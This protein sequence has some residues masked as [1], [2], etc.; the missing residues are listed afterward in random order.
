MSKIKTTSAIES[1]ISLRKKVLF[2]L[3][4]TMLFFGGLEIVLTVAGVRPLLYDEDPHVGFVS[5]IPLFVEGKNGEMMTAPN[6]LRWFNEQRFERNK[7]EGVIRVF[8]VG[9]STT[10]GR[11]YADSTSFCGWLREY[12]PVADPTKTWE[13][14]NA[15]G[16]SYASYRVAKL[17]EELAS[18][19]PDVF[20]IYSGHNEFLEE[21]TY[22]GIIETPEAVL[23]MQ[24]ALGHT[25]TYSFMAGLLH[26][27]RTSKN[28]SATPV[29]S[30]E[31]DTI[32]DHS[33]G[34]ERYTRDE[35][36]EAD[37]MAHYRYNLARMVDIAQ[38]ANAR[39]IFISPASNLGNASP[40][41]SEHDGGMTELLVRDW[42]ALLLSAQRDLAA[43]HYE[44]ALSAINRALAMDPLHA[45]TL[46][47]RGQ[48]LEALER[49]EDAK[50]SYIAALENDVCPLRILPKMRAIL[51]ETAASRGVD[52]FDYD[53]FLVER[54]AHG[55][56]G[57]EWFLDHVHPTVEGHRL[58][59]L[60]VIKVMETDG[61]LHEGSAL[62]DDSIQKIKARVLAGI[63]DEAQGIALRNLGNVLNWAGKKE[64]AYAAA[65]KALKLA[66]G[67]AYTHYLLGD[68]AGSL[69]E[70]T[71][72][73]EHFR[74]LIRFDLNT[75]DAPYFPDAHYQLAQIV[76]AR[77]NTG[78]S[79]KL[80]QKTLELQPDHKGA[81][82]ALPIVLEA[83]GKKLLQR[84]RTAE[85]VAIFRKLVSLVP[86]IGMAANFLGA[87][88]I[89]D[90]KIPEAIE[91]LETAVANDPQNPGIHN[92][93][94]SAFAQSG[95]G[96][97]AAH[98]FETAIQ[99]N[100]DHADAH[101]NYA[102]LLESTGKLDLAAD[103]Y[104]MVLKLQPSSAEAA[105]AL[106]RILQQVK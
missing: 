76:G 33:A 95:N 24:A 37:I 91:V 87:A 8:C 102:R 45:H 67:D 89:Q 5:S 6:K 68:L 83:H 28:T 100:P 74:E 17:M 70:T 27:S 32:L 15:G 36:L 64:E 54:S 97:E 23:G 94:G 50:A 47:L 81:E 55:I 22:S 48:V 99:L 66:P 21:R 49:Y 2:S 30:E 40:F 34:L 25:R 59:A 53:R 11:P 82:A 84:G 26:R 56:P 106:K 51:A 29:L 60:E 38:S 101:L 86:K 44:E 93:L 31:V 80:I 13:V 75:R 79:L 77:G 78:E 69:G 90:K 20:V 105:E 92:N 35:K 57:D 98:H 12:L 58:L 7:P 39:V 85:A 52:I 4:T 104:R 96:E 62:S 10:Y 16:I 72:A 1:R 65:T 19:E 9:G 103:Y 14:I 71:E 61:L 88:L 3:L 41:K 73:E 63:D 18:Y 43:E 42:E 46:Y